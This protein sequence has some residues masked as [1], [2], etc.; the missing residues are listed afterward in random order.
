MEKCLVLFI[1]EEQSLCQ[2]FHTGSG[3]RREVTKISIPL[4]MPITQMPDR[5]GRASVKNRRE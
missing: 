3:I 4:K 5:L 2:N 1:S